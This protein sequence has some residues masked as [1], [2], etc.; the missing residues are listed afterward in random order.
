MAEVR[1]IL[2]VMKNLSFHIFILGGGFRGGNDRG[3]GGF[4]GG[5]DRGRGGF[6]GGNDRG[7]GG[8]RGGSFGGGRGGG[9]RGGNDRGRGGGFR[10][11]N[12]R[13]RGG[14]FRGGSRGGGNFG[15]V[16]R[17]FMTDSIYV[18][19]LPSD[20]KENDLKKLFPKVKNVTLSPAEGTRPG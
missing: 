11:G 13:G 17:E 12:D 2:L 8:F 20:I 3:R 14:G 5:N 18:G 15:D 10:D 6:R 1:Y 9:F 7:R 4:R 19:Q 16:K